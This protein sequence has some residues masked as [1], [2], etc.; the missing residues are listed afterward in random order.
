MAIKVINYHLHDSNY[1]DSN[2]DYDRARGIGVSESSESESDSD[3]EVDEES[4]TEENDIYDHDNPVRTGTCHIS[5]LT[6]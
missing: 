2:S 6:S 4:N 3:S 1:Y 5:I